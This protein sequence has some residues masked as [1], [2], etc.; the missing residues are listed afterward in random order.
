MT[1]THDIPAMTHEARLAALGIVLPQ[2]AP[3]PIGAFR[4]L[5]RHGDSLYVSGQG[6]VTADGTL[7]RGK[8]GTEVSADEARAHARLVAINILAVLR[9]EFGSLDAIGG[10]VK[11]TG[12]VNADPDFEAHPHVIDGASEVMHQVFGEA[13]V[14]ARTSIGVG[15]L[16]NRITVEIEAVFELA[17]R[18]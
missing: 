9:D 5:R 6:P 3:R 11:L 14:H 13:G 4:N 10:V 16:P 7:L 17:T 12:L 1:M 15:S 2:A 8:V 18:R